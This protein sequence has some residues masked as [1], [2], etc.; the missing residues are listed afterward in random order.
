MVKPSVHVPRPEPDAAE[1]EA[2]VRLTQPR[3]VAELRVILLALLLTPGSQRER[4]AWQDETRGLSTARDLR[5][6]VKLLGPALRLPCFEQL[7]GQLTKGS[8]SDRTDLLE[9][10]RRIMAADGQIRPIDRLFWLA[11]R[12]RLGEATPATTQAS[13]L[14]EMSAL[15][16]H[17][18]REIGRVTA[19]LS[20]LVPD[21]TALQGTAWYNAVMGVWLTAPQL[22]RCE[23]PDAD[24]LVNALAEVQSLPMMLRPVLVRAWA[25]AAGEQALGPAAADALRLGALLLDCPIP[26]ELARHYLES[27]V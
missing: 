9:A 2:F 13:A 24:G 18:L 8:L 27:V 15:S 16:L 22:P 25:D 5:Q 20:R 21:G 1:R 3:G 23:P 14:N 6:Q 12:H 26:P 19:F 17:T 10:A 7:M 4:R 11:L